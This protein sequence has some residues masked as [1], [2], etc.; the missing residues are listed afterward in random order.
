MFGFFKKLKGEER[1]RQT[2]YQIEINDD[3]I[4]KNIS[5]LVLKLQDKI[6]TFK[7]HLETE[8]IEQ[9]EEDFQ[10]MYEF[11]LN[12]K[13]MFKELEDDVEKIIALE[14]EYKTYF[15]IK[16]DA[17]L[18]DKREQ[19]KMILN[20]IDAFLTIVQQ[21]PSFRDLRQELF[22]KMVG[23]INT[24]SI[25]VSKIVRDDENLRTIYKKLSEI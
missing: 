5:K 19:I 11:I 17:F 7:S 18:L 1:A 15:I 2:L 6:K 14:M 22:D 4:N 25:G 21:R 12:I 16:D 13:T 23:A 8:N 24:M 9:K 10:T 20:N 3:E